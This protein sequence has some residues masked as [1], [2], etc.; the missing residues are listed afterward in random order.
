[1]AINV[2]SKKREELLFAPILAFLSVFALV[3]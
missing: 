3:L 1:M 2:I